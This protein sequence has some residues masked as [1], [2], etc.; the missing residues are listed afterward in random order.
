MLFET[1]ETSGWNKCNFCHKT[2]NIINF[3]FKVSTLRNVCFVQK[4]PTK[5]TS[6]ELCLYMQV[7]PL[8][9]HF[10]VEN[11]PIGLRAYRDARCRNDRAPKRPCSETSAPKRPVPKH[12]KP[13]R[14]KP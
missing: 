13:K 4:Q 5:I 6:S 11:L 3:F 14:P 9:K 10:S 7:L 12:A 8:K 1:F 2:W